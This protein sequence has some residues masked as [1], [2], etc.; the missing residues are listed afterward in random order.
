MKKTGI[1]HRSFEISMIKERWFLHLLAQAIMFAKMRARVRY[2]V[3][4]VIL[5]KVYV[6]GM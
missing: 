5:Y 1:F 6:F 3:A 4:L 2:K